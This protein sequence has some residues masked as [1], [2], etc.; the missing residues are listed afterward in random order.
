LLQL[1]LPL[2]PFVFFLKA[3][4]LAIK[5]LHPNIMFTLPLPG[6]LFYSL[7]VCC[8]P[9]LLPLFSYTPVAVVRDNFARQRA[10]C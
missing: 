6:G 7:H 1:K 10:C 8:S 2:P 3:L 9:L 4:L 5:L